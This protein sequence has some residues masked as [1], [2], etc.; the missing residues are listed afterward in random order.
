MKDHKQI[1]RL[2]IREEVLWVNT[3]YAMPGTMEGAILIAS[4][5]RTA[6]ERPGVLDAFKDL[7]RAIV[8]EIVF[9]ES[10]MRPVWGGE[11]RAPEH[12]RAGKA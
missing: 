10:G 3:Y 7:G 4:V 6:A 2:A 12:E 8:S 5:R 11:K 1:G 9:E